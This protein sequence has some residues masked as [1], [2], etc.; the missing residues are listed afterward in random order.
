MATGRI[1]RTARRGIVALVLGWLAVLVATVAAA[2]GASAAPTATVDIRTLTP[3]VVSV[4][5]GGTVTFVNH[6]ATYDSA[7]T[8]PLVGGVK[9]TVHTDVSVTFFGQ[10]RDLQFGQSTQWAFPSTT[11]GTITY[12]YRI[13]PQAGLAANLVNQVVNGVAATLPPLPAPVPYVVETLVPLPTLPSTN[14]PDLPEVNVQVPGVPNA[15]APGPDGTPQPPTGGVIDVP[16][17]GTTGGTPQS[18]PGTQYTYDTGSGAPQMA[19]VDTAA[20]AAFDPARFYVPG[21][22][23]GSPDR[24][25]GSGMGAGGVTGNYD[26]A[27]VPVFGQLA[28]LDGSDLEEADS[29]VAAPGAASGAGLPVP[30]LAAVVALAA[31]TA[32]LVRTQQAHRAARSVHRSR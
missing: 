6:V 28:G 24:F 31:V 26:G 15:P 22:S 14:L 29:A 19:P 8:L 12:T 3:P 1:R 32:A 11:A 27:T 18:I 17:G 20:A 16:Q 25:A 30:A 23:T 21:R 9:A 7:V 10:K 13:V 4:D 5:A 2:P